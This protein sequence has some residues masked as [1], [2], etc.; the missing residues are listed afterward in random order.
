VS[1]RVY[2]G[3][4]N[5]PVDQPAIDAAVKD[6]AHVRWKAPL[7]LVGSPTKNGYAD[8]DFAFGETYVYV[9]RT[10]PA[11]GAVAQAVEAAESADS[12]PAVITPKDIFP[13]SAPQGLVAAV[14]DGNS[15]AGPVVELSWSIAPES[16]VAGYR[17]YRSERD[18][19]RG[20]SLAKELVPTP[21]YR[22]ASV[23]AGHRYWY[24]VTAVDRAGNESPAGAAVAA[25][26]GQPA[27]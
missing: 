26:I 24:T 1:Y 5:P 16:D 23:Q 27:S 4:L 12:V 11:P 19:E 18:G 6:L 2:R 14:L 13:P 9:V 10:V 22:D 3:Q 7:A 20:E 25:E 17:V 21:A 15:G 8:T